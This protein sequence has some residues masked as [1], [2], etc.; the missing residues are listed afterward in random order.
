L[1]DY[2]TVDPSDARFKYTAAPYI[3][4]PLLAYD[5]GNTSTEAVDCAALLQASEADPEAVLVPDAIFD[6]LAACVKYQHY[7]SNQAQ[8]PDDNE[9]WTWANT[10]TLGPH[11][12]CQCAPGKV[13]TSG[14]ATVSGI[15]SATVIFLAVIILALTGF[16]IVINPMLLRKAERLE[17]VAVARGKEHELGPLKLY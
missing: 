3:T 12:V 4:L 15:L 13:C 5:P 7:E 14:N 9:V 17:R 8:C 11:L 6:V 16:T 2:A 10:T 1:S